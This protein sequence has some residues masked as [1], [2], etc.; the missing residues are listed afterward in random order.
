MIVTGGAGMRR[1]QRVRRYVLPVAIAAALALATAGP[2]RGA[3]PAPA[4]TSATPTDE[5]LRAVVI[6]VLGEERRVIGET[7]EP[8][9]VVVARVRAGAA[10]EVRAE[11]SPPPGTERTALLRPGD[12]II[13]TRLSDAPNA[14]YAVVDRD[15]LA[16]LLIIFALFVAG[17]VYFSRIRGFTSVIGLMITIVVLARFV[18]PGILGGGNPLTVSLAGALVIA[19]VSIYLAH[20]FSRRTSVALLGTL[21]TLALS[22]V[23]AIVFV[24][25][26]W[27]SGSGSEEAMYLALGPAA[28]VNLRGLL[29]GGIILG[30]LGVLD[31]ITTGQ[32]AAVD[33]I[34]KANPALPPA[35]LYRRGLSVG[36]EHITSLVNTLVL[37]YAGA[38]LPLFLLFT[39]YAD[40]PFW[41]TINS[42]FLAEE[43][44]R[45][46]VG[47]L[48]LILAVPIT[49]LLAA[50]L[51]RHTGGVVST[52]NIT[53]HGHH[54]R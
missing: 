1:A 29:L 39:V 43:I 13:I 22:A 30:A 52:G 6:R 48:T 45:T 49:T 50:R 31:D 20:G 33:E 28:A 53:A 9:Q 11:Y 4:R 25:L 42:E 36:Q 24:R 3:P 23:L 46:L 54:H 7:P 40:Q 27:L 10:S 12:R 19:L 38:S 8:V 17:A 14:P 21:I 44:V 35:E 18:V 5:F 2:M 26:A 41:V 51:L 47:S 32:A 34:S 16:P 15:R 37:A